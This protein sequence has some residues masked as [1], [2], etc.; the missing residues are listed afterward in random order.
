MSLFRQLWLTVILTTLV[1]FAGSF[2]VSVLT[3]RSYLE[4]QLYTQSVDNAASLALSMSQQ[5]K[6]LETETLLVSALFDNGHFQLIRFN[7]PHGKPLIERVNR[8]PPDSVPDWFV[9]LFPL[10]APPGMAQVTDGWRQAGVVTVV[11][12]TR[13]AHQA[14]WDGTLRLLVWIML[15]GGLTGGLGTVMLRTIRRPLDRVVEQADAI[16]ERRFISVPEPRVPELKRVVSAMNAM[17]ARVKAMFEEEAEHIQALRRE[18]NSDALTQLANRSYFDARVE[19]MLHD[20]EAA[21]SGYYFWLRLSDLATLNTVFGHDRTDALLKAVAE[22]LGEASAPHPEWLPARI[23]GTD[24]ALLAP[25]LPRLEADGLAAALLKDLGERLPDGGAAGNLL[26][27]GVAEY[28]RGVAGA[29]LRARADYALRSATDK[30]ENAVALRHWQEGQQEPQVDWRALLT[31]ALEGEGFQLTGF[32]VVHMDG[33][34]LH[35]EMALRLRHPDSGE[36]LNAGAFMPQ[37]ARLGLL[38][39]LDIVVLRL[40]LELL[41]R[42]VERT[43]ALNIS[44]ESLQSSEFRSRLVLALREHPDC[45][46][47]LWLEVS[48]HGLS[49]ELTSLEAFAHRLRPLQVHIGLDHFGRQFNALPL[50]HE[51]GLDYLK[52]DAALINGID[53]HE[54]NQALIKAVVGIA[55][56]L[57]VMTVAERV[58]TQ[59][60]WD[61]LRGL[62]VNGLTGPVLATR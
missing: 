22:E 52:L 20:E 11:A 44:A 41:R 18:A 23:G 1:A 31:R 39:Q 14:L 50:L 30:G 28:R 25:G 54:G 45:A 40:A 27:I 60:E 46:R 24:F 21:A 12:H 8:T 47:R 61:C 38:P 53:R 36:V 29:E 59:A 48:D 15:A 55:E 43:L 3:A 5:S 16:T 57:G 34:P 56:A 10:H 13:F 62:G 37:A 49:T 32:A 26:H 17:V 19:H 33:S 6:D 35:E 4:Q 2:V 58:Q 42:D 7:D 51:L 9:R